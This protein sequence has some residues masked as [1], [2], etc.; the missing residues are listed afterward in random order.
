VESTRAFTR[1]PAHVVAE[2]R[3]KTGLTARGRVENLS[4]NGLSIPTDVR[5]SPGTPCSVRLFLETGRDP[6]PLDGAGVVMRCQDGSVALRLDEMDPDAFEHLT[7]L[8]LYNS[9]DAA[10]IERESDEHVDRHPA[11]HPTEPA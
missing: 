8:V 6:I 1:V 2:L 5:F 11:L 7:K 9:S 10:A 3:S 4:L